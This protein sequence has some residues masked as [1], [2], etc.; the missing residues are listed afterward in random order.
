MEVFNAFYAKLKGIRLNAPPVVGA[1]AS[2]TTSATAATSTTSATAAATTPVFGPKGLTLQE[3]RAEIFARLK[4][5]PSKSLV[6]QGDTLETLEC[7]FKCSQE[8]FS[9][10][11][12]L[13]DVPLSPKSLQHLADYL[14]SE[15]EVAASSKVVASPKAGGSS[16]T[17]DTGVSANTTSAVASNSDVGV[18]LPLTSN[19]ENTSVVLQVSEVLV[20]PV[21]SVEDNFLEGNKFRLEDNRL[22]QALDPYNLPTY[23]FYKKQ[24]SKLVDEKSLTKV[25]NT[26][27][28][29]NMVKNSDHL[30][31]FVKP[32]GLN[33]NF[34]DLK[35]LEA[36]SKGS[37]FSFTNKPT[38][39]ILEAKNKSSAASVSESAEIASLKEALKVSEEALTVAVAVASAANAKNAAIFLAGILLCKSIGL[40]FF[41]VVMD[42]CLIT[43]YYA[44]FIKK[45]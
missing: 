16:S 23:N 27:T 11:K 30:S 28:T 2:T 1:I 40:L 4:A 44:I 14:A 17:T 19:T 34:G 31:S 20:V 22:H 12:V 5:D 35:H 39:S 32:N 45:E 3:Y 10:L 8:H 13:N 9:K 18:I 41:T 36:I 21:V 25:S 24:D 37:K 38:S 6:E 33:N 15:E 7:K 42:Y 26:D 29:S 43:L